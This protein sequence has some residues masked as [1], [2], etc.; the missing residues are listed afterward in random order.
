MPKL[1]ILA[2]LFLVAL[3]LLWLLGER[4]GLGRLPGDIV[5]ERENFKLY[6]PLASSLLVSVLLSAAFWF[7]NR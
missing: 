2:G 5:I 3:G 6:I 1:L 7:F 4:F